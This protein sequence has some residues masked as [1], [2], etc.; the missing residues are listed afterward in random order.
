MLEHKLVVDNLASHLCFYFILFAS[1]SLLKHIIVSE[2]KM[3]T[4]ELKHKLLFEYKIVYT[5]KMCHRSI[6]FSESAVDF[7]FSSKFPTVN[8]D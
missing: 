2:S 8:T 6:H 3:H 5:A 4:I 1:I 7:E